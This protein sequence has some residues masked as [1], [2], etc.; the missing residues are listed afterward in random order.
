MRPKVEH[1]KIELNYAA[2]TRDKRAPLSLD[3]LIS[4]AESVGDK[5]F[6][7]DLYGDNADEQVLIISDR[8]LEPGMVAD[9]AGKM[10]G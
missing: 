3:E 7:T 8:Y 2:I 9:L 4:T 10:E 5:I 1:H 6:I